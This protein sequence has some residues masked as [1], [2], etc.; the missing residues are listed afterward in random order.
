MLSV[1]GG[2]EQLEA[3]LHHLGRHLSEGV[4][5]LVDVEV[6]GVEPA[7][8]QAGVREIDGAGQVDEVPDREVRMGAEK[9]DRE[10]RAH[11]VADDRAG[12]GLRVGQ[13]LPPH[14]G[15]DARGAVGERQMVVLGTEDAPVEQIEGKPLLHHV[16]DEAGP[17]QQVED[18]GTADAQIGHEQNRGAVPDGAVVAVQARLVLAVDLL[19]GA[20]RDDRLVG[21]GDQLADVA[22]A[23][24]SALD[25]GLPARP[26]GSVAG[27]WTAPP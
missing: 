3:E 21:L 9:A 5:Q 6:A 7:A 23:S 20:L 10:G 8:E 24:E 27:A 26:G 18:G 2:A 16:L 11:A 13:Q 12:V 4:D 19:A 17:G 1:H 14:A 22:N 25:L 15:Q